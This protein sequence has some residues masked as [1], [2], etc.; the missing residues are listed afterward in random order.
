[1]GLPVLTLE[2]AVGTV[3]ALGT[4]DADCFFFYGARPTMGKAN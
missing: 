2:F 3:H 1:M 4:A